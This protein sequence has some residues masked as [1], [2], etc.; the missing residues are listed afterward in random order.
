MR[1]TATAR[2]RAPTAAFSPQVARDVR[3]R[4]QETVMTIVRF[5]GL[6]LAGA[7]FVSASVA[8]GCSS[9]TNAPSFTNTNTSTTNTSASSGGS[10]LATTSAA[11]S[12]PN[13]GG[14][15]TGQASSGSSSAAGASTA[16]TDAGTDGGVCPSTLKDKVTTC[17]VGVDPSCT[18]GCG[19]D[20]P[21]GSSQSNLGNKTCTCMT[22]VYQCG[23]CVYESP[24]PGCYVES[25]TPPACDA[26]VV[27]KGTCTTPCSGAGTGND[28]CAMITD[29]GKSAGCVCIQGS[30]GPVWTC[31]TLPW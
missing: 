9:D 3:D 20:L 22:G 18:K 29:A 15:S 25:A 24:L 21:A 31:A 8:S 17:T 27:D 14:S 2:D 12:T 26:T 19:P 23:S 1:I 13:A 28:V 11:A 6:V 5:T 30:T 7:S 10:A 4:S 16:S